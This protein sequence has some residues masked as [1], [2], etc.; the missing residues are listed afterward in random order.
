MTKSTPKRI[1]SEELKSFSRISAAKL[2][3]EGDAPRSPLVPITPRIERG[4]EFLEYVDPSRDASELVL[5]PAVERALYDITQEHKIADKFRRHHIPVRNRL[6]FC[7]PP[8]CGKTATAEAFARRVGLP[9]MVGKLDAVFG[10]LF[11]ETASNLSKMFSAAER[12]PVVLFLDEFD[13]LAR[14]REDRSEHNEMRRIVNNLLLLIDKFKGRGFIV[15]ATNLEATIDSALLRRFDEVVFFDIPS[16]SNIRRLLKL[17]TQ[18][19]GTEFDIAAQ[20]E[21]LRGKS[22]A[23]IER[24]CYQAIR[25]AIMDNRSR[26][27]EKDFTYALEGEARRDSIRAKVEKLPR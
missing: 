22:Y 27:S 23:D 26:I 25:R 2:A 13:A 9:M 5:S 8:G 6:L 4:T 16:T 24:I 14:T 17:R 3:R 7:G 18:N 21:L 19:F 20:A 1:S 12:Q 11:G 10:S 15:A